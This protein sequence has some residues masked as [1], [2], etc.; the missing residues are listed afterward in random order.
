MSGEDHRRGHQRLG[1]ILFAPHRSIP[2]HAGNRSPGGTEQERA[3]EPRSDEA[4]KVGTRRVALMPDRQRK[5]ML[6][7][8]PPG[9]PWPLDAVPICLTRLP[10]YKVKPVP[11]TFEVSSLAALAVGPTTVIRSTT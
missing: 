5:E 11:S 4:Q 8:K 6:R 7:T 9:K 2:R 1:S 10:L 3:G